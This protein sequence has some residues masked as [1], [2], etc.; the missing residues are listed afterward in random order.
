MDGV[1]AVYSGNLPSILGSTSGED[2]RP[3]RVFGLAAKCFPRMDGGEIWRG[4]RICGV[5]A[6]YPGLAPSMLV[7]MAPP[8]V[9]VIWLNMDYCIYTQYIFVG[10]YGMELNQSSTL[11]GRVREV[12]RY[13]HYS[14]RTERT[15]VEW[16]RRFVAFHGRRHPREMGAEEVRAF[17]GYLAAELKVAASTHQQALSALL[18]LYRDVL[19]IDL[20]WLTDLDRPKKP[21]R[22]PVVLSR[23]EVERLLAVMEGTHALMAR[24]LYGTG[25]R[26]MEC[27][28]LRVKDVDFDRKVIV[29]RSGKGGKDR[30]VM[31]PLS[32]V[33]LLTA[34]LA[35]SRSLWAADRASGHAGVFMPHALD[36]KYPRAAQSWAWHWV[37]PSNTLCAI[38]SPHT[39]F[40]RALTS[41]P[42][43]SFWATAMSV[44]Q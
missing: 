25:M 35:K 14:I 30:V 42:C 9:L 5:S 8:K 20:P 43:K 36:A 13:K 44:Q 1:F 18:F 26:L 27:V 12:I 24:L 31:L 21:K 4:A 28:R 41:E 17:L 3:E 2:G 40:N 22:T 6:V 19:G 39:C 10:R 11:L 7:N 32:L 38:R 37:F 33:P 34:Q 15:Y 23:G 29:V 16:V